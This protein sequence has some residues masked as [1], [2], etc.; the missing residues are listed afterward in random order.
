VVAVDCATE[1][2]NISTEGITKF[3]LDTAARIVQLARVADRVDGLSHESRDAER[4]QLL[5]VLRLRSRVLGTAV[6]LSALSGWL[7]ITV[8]PRIAWNVM[9]DEAD[10]KRFQ[11]APIPERSAAASGRIG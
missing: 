11:W 2:L 7:K 8:L 10:A 5:E 4:D 3:N 6:V 9:T 1:G